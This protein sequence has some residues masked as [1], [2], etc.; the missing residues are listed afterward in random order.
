MNN[1]LTNHPQQKLRIKFMFLNQRQKRFFEK[2]K[3]KQQHIIK[4]A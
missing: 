1:F 2:Q 4:K 3:K